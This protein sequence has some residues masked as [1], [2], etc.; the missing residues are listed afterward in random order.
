MESIN[1][2]WR[3]HEFFAGWL[4]ER[5]KP[6]TIVELG[7]DYGFS[8]FSFAKP[9]I[10]TVYGIDSF[11]GDV[12]A[13]FRNTHDEVMK[14]KTELKLDNIEL[15]KGY[16][17]EVAKTW[18]KPIDILHID[19]R[20]HYEDVKED[21][22]NWIK[23]LKPNGV[24]LMHDT[25]IYTNNFGVHRFFNEIQIPKLNFTHSAGLGV[26]SKDIKLL[27]DVYENFFK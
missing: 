27:N 11:E 14:L 7:V 6:E 9:K 25:C 16:F 26:L 3:G 1:T 17:S 22:E 21:Y 15:V 19:G 5:V 23:H 8:T 2:A 24:V 4:V 12:H 10:G 18:D 13:G 20:H